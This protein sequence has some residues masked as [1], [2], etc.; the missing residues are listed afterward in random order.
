MLS[1]PAHASGQHL[2]HIS[3][4]QPVIPSSGLLATKLTSEYTAAALYASAAACPVIP[5]A[6][7]VR[8]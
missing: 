8:C 4:G 6:C 3:R 2:I 1:G 7:R 5:E